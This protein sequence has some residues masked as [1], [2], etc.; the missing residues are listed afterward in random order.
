MGFWG[1][2]VLGPPTIDD[3]TGEIV[4]ISV[5]GASGFINQPAVNIVGGTSNTTPAISS[6]GAEAVAKLTG[7]SYT[8]P[9]QDEVWGAFGRSI[10][11][12]SVALGTDPAAGFTYDFTVNG[13]SI[14][15]T[16]MPFL[17]G[18]PDGVIWTPPLP[19]VYSIVSTTSDGDGNTAVSSAVRYFAVGTAFVS[20]EAG[21]SA[22]FNSGQGFIA[23][24][25][26]VPVGSSIVLQATSTPEDGFIQEIDFYTDWDASSG[27][28]GIGGASSG[29][30]CWTRNPDRKRDHQELSLFRHLFAC[31]C[32]EHD[33]SAEGRGLGQQ[34]ESHSRAEQQSPWTR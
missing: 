10:Y 17:E 27:T 2:G 18:V 22:P 34:R 20:P 19:G 4:S 28:T 5:A 9:F 8:A 7:A 32:G 29:S 16:A 15:S 24:G 21:S 33:P 31:G 26:L 13:L 25:V 14:G 3:A 23:P 1:F 6:S 11:I 12:W 30:R